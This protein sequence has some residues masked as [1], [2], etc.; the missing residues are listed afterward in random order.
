MQRTAT[1][2]YPIPL[3]RRIRAYCVQHDLTLSRFFELAAELFLEKAV[4]R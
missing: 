2:R 4:A 3:A 1:I